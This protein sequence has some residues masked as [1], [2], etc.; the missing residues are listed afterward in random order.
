MSQSRVNLAT[1]RRELAERQDEVNLFTAELKAAQEVM[2]AGGTG[3]KT[4]TVVAEAIPCKFII[5]AG[6][7]K[8]DLVLMAE[9]TTVS[10][11]T[12]GQPSAAAAAAA[13]EPLAAAGCP[14][15][16]IEEG[17]VTDETDE[18]VISAAD[19]ADTVEA[20][21]T[22]AP[23]AP[24]ED[25]A[26]A[27][28]ETVQAAAAAA[29][30]DA[31]GDH[32]TSAADLA[33]ASTA[34]QASVVRETEAVGATEAEAVKDG[35]ETAAA[36]DGEGTAAGAGASGAE[37]G[38][39]A[40]AEDAAGG[41]GAMATA[42][43][44][45][46]MTTMT[47]EAV[48]ETALLETANQD[49]SSPAVAAV[50][51]CSTA[52]TEVVVPSSEL[53]LKSSHGQWRYLEADSTPVHGDSAVEV[54]KG[55]RFST[56]LESLDRKEDENRVVQLA[57]KLDEAEQ[58]ARSAEAMIKKLQPAPAGAGTS[59]RKKSPG[60]AGGRKSALKKGKGAGGTR[61]VKSD[62]RKR[63]GAVVSAVSAAI[64]S[65]C[66]KAKNAGEF[67]WGSRNLVFFVSAVALM[68]LHGD[69][70]AV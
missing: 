9:H 62:A 46:V 70:L 19:A 42:T 63:K 31:V 1:A 27:V 60:G 65:A 69:Y 6:T 43:A 56:T 21:S 66:G 29:A 3:P 33:E 44:A 58:R 13:E 18:V 47:A 54:T 26:G 17:N 48:A 38:G 25:E 45:M 59:S 35:I 51:G 34:E 2:A 14:L 11:P 23:A 53:D 12:N 49:I 28:E 41:D 68:H 4:L 5:D 22:A 55:V 64:G 50:L 61:A 16:P 67:A 20:E 7:D 36:T 37:E 8:F 15:S 30:V 57:I 40:G 10:A 24:I 32:D 39:T 52:T